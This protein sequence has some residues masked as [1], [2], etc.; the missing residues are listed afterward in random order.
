VIDLPLVSLDLEILDSETGSEIIEVGA[1]KFRGGES[2]DTFSALIRPK[3]TLSFRVGNLTGLTARDLARG[4]PL[5]VVLDRLSTFVGGVGIVGQSIGLDLEHL[6]RAGLDL[7]N[8]RFDT[9]EL[10]VLL[11]PGL[12]AYDLGSIARELGVGGDIPH[13]ALA[14]A[15]LARAVFV[16]LVEDAARLPLETLA[17]VVRLAAPL[18]WPLKLVFE[19][20]QQRRVQ[21]MLRAGS[22]D[23]F[24]TGANPLD[25]VKPP[26]VAESLEP[27]D[28]FQRI[29][30]KALGASIGPTGNVARS[31]S[32]YEDRPAQRRMLAAVAM[33]LNEGD[34]LLVEAG[35]GTGKSLAYLLP[36]LRFSVDNGMRVVV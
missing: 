31:L 25:A 6:K 2:L 9:F 36:A 20:L 16:A 35:T 18:D 23:G 28:G 30:A 13:R 24:T 21:E 8:R 34:T 11:R 19:Q 29:D 5:N 33:A 12:K 27:E 4:E 1:V 15:E 3:G 7:A 22:V 26:V 14:D 10:A 32:G 17:Q